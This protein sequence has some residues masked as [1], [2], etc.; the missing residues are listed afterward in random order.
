MEKF[1]HKSIKLIKIIITKIFVFFVRL[2]QILVSPLI[3]YNACR[4]NP[5]CSQYMIEALEKKGPV[6]GLLLGTWRL[7]KCHPWS[8]GGNDEVK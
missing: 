6:K 8:A 4:F 2:Y 1:I 5:S 7:L 3:S